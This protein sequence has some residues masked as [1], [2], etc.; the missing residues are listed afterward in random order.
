MHTGRE[1]WAERGWSLDLNHDDPITGT[2]WDLS[3]PNVQQKVLKMI[4][5]EK[6]Q[7]IIGSPP[8]SLFSI[9]Q[10]G[11]PNNGSK[12]LL[13]EYEKAKENV[14]FC[15]KI[16]R[17]QMEAG[18]MLMHEHPT[19]ASSWKLPEI[20]SLKKE[21]G[22][23]YRNIHMCAYGL[24]A[25]NTKGDELGSAMKA[26]GIMTNSWAVHRQVDRRC[27]KDHRHTHLQGAN[28]AQQASQ[29]T[30]EFCTHVLKAISTELKQ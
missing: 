23:Y 3:L 30:D 2:K 14:R 22:V 5:E 16:Y 26:R 25:R 1:V 29:Y 24:K 28:R 13:E 8:C 11:N 12:E 4:R 19:C 9:L 6:P 18:R 10:N 17:M 15:I 20:D 27:R 7:M 21:V